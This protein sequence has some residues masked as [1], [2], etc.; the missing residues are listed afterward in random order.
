MERPYWS[1]GA[2]LPTSPAL[3]R[4]LTVD[5]VVVGGGIT[6]ATAALLMKDAGLTVALVERDRCG[7]GDTGHTSAHLTAV[8]D[9]TFPQLIESFG[10]P[11]AEAVWDGGFAALHEISQIVSQ[12]DIE[13]AFRWVPGYLTTRFDGS[14]D[15]DADLATL[16]D[17]AAEASHSGFDAT[18]VDGVPGVGLPAVRFDHQARMRPLEYLAALL[19]AIPGD[20]S[21]VFERCP[22]TTIDDDPLVVHSGAH[23]IHTKFVVIA[24]HIPITGKTNLLKA[25]LLQTDLYP[26]SSYVV[27]AK[28]EKGLWPDALIWDLS[29]P[30]YFVRLDER[31]D[32]DVLIVGGCDHKTGQLEETRR[33]F[34]ELIALIAQWLPDAKITHKWTGQIVE[35]RDGLPYIGETAPGQFVITGFGGNGI[36]FGT[37]GAM[38]ARDAALGTRNPWSGLFDANRTHITKGIWDYV[39]E[40]VDYP[41]YMIRDRFSGADGRDLRAVG[42]GEGKIIDLRGNRVAASRNGAGTLSVVSPVCTHMGCHVAWNK[43]DSTWDCPCHGSRFSPSGRVLRGPAEK[44]LHRY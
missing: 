1:A 8:T 32:H 3:D 12:H 43:A 44:D 16:E 24:T 10:R 13:C 21:H 5:A 22:V 17:V 39:R 2:E 26:Y 36:T 29:D 7:L 25:T 35:T 6:G 18:M 41:Y 42:R 11:H 19:A 40:N 28:V 34:D 38:M 20:G 37:L 27:S 15:T 30:Y 23:K 31:D 33:P 9:K 4:D 14:T